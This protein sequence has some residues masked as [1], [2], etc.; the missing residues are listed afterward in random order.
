[1][2]SNTSEDIVP[3]FRCPLNRVTSIATPP[4][5]ETGGKFFAT[6]QFLPLRLSRKGL[7]PFFE[8]LALGRVMRLVRTAEADIVLTWTPKPNLYAAIAGRLLRVPVIPNVS[9]LGVVFI[10]GGLFARLIGAL[11]GYAFARASVV[12]F[13]NEEDR[14]AF[15]AGGR[16]DPTKSARLPGSGVGLKKFIPAP[17]P[18]A[19][20][21]VFLYIGRLLADKG[22]R[23]LADAARKLRDDGRQVELRIAGFLDAG[24]PAGIGKAE[25]DSW[26]D[27]GLVTYI[28]PLQ[29]VR[30]ALRGAHCAVL[31]S[32]YREGVPRS[33]LEA[34]AMGRPIITTDTPGCRDTVV[35]DES[36]FLCEPRSADSLA[37]C[38]ERMLDLSPEAL[39]EMG[40]AGRGHVEQ[41]FS[42]EIVLDAYLLWCRK[43][44][45]AAGGSRRGESVSARETA[46]LTVYPDFGTKQEGEDG[47]AG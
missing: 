6:R 38:M 22:L 26:I 21:F 4:S 47:E 1:L 14:A 12:F 36:G 8:L 44:M 29:D 40:R 30:P 19:E 42:E 35:P 39:A 32:Y 10:K 17:L 11:Y 5:D 16:I 28:G 18:S 20:P 13:Q 25:L 31:P 15:I 9:G 43:L 27:E 33:L 34:A 3:S 2:T 46:Q 41:H 23:E 24:N 37:S 7:N 45:T